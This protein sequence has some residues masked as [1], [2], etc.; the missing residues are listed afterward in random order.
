MNHWLILG[1][2]GQLGRC[3]QGALTERG[4]PFVALNSSECDITDYQVVDVT[5]D[6]HSPGVVVNCAAW[7]A[8][9]AA[10]DNETAAFLANC[11]GA[12]N[13]ARACRKQQCILV[14]LSTDY[15]FSGYGVGPMNEEDPTSPVSVYGQSKLC[16]EQRVL[17]IHSTQ[18]YIVR[19]AWLYSKYGKN[20]A[21]TML[22]RAL[23]DQPVKVV[24]DQSG[25]PTSA[26]DLAHHLI[27]LV[28]KSAPPGIYHG[29]NAGHATWFDFAREIFDI[30]GR[31]I[32]LVSPVDS[33]A[34]P[35]RATRPRN[36]VLGHK[37]T[38]S[39]GVAEMQHWKSALAHVFSEIE[40]EVKQ[41]DQ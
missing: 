4:I 19:T 40:N 22:R 12:E 26:A 5:L 39:A 37:R 41:E 11:S 17:E 30:A 23:A 1:G 9:D 35:T 16:G 21:K 14:H 13:V 6:T 25:Q 36:S 7:T 3:L 10:E 2:A 32:S 29:T 34:Y 33:S 38:I 18:S 20:F 31:G 15:V 27:D 8:V 24:N 28:T